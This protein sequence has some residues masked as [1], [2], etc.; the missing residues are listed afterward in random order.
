MEQE[1]KQTGWRRWF[2][3]ACVLL[4]TVPPGI[5]YAWSTVVYFGPAK[6]MAAASGA[7]TNGFAAREFNRVWR[8]T[9]LYFCVEYYHTNGTKSIHC[10][11]S[12]NPVALNWRDG[13][14]NAI[15]FNS[16]GRSSY[17]TT[18]STTRP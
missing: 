2:L 17:P 1:R 12:E 3:I 16:S 5:A 7:A 6:T 9:P 10:S 11:S 14:A 15:C 13:Y 4:V 8:P 18:C